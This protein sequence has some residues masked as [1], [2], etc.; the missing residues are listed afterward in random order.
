MSNLGIMDL[1]RNHDTD[2]NK[3]GNAI[4][5]I[6]EDNE[7]LD[8][9]TQSNRAD[10]W[11]TVRAFVRLRQQIEMEFQA[12]QSVYRGNDPKQEQLVWAAEAIRAIL[13]DF[14][15]AGFDETGGPLY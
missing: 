10:E 3:W 4:R 15:S 9:I 7:I 12:G 14:K 8:A 13:A 11:A 2:L 1:I 5:Q 6:I